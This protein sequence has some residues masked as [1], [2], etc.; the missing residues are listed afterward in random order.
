MDRTRAKAAIVVGVLAVD[1]LVH[2]YWST[3]ATWPAASPVA[4]S[5]AVLNTEVP[6]TP[7]VVLPL[8]GVLAGSAGMV[9]LRARGRG[10]RAAVLVT[11]AV[12]GGLAL[13]GAAGLVWATGVGADT[14]T[15]FY[16]LNLLAYTPACLG[17]AP[18]A[19]GLARGS[20]SERRTPGRWAR[21]RARAA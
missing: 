7:A 16:W 8:A 12:S 4:L 17:L 3:G 9:A 15:L 14:G 18:L 6:F 5:R 13:R 11:G 1:S 2:L 10:G 21:S 19:F 20:V